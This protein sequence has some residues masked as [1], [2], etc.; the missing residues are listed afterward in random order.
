MHFP[1]QIR[2][3]L[4]VLAVLNNNTLHGLVAEAF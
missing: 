1:K 3:Q 2:D 4:K